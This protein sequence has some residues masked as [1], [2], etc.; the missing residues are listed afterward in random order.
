MIHCEACGKSFSEVFE[1]IP[2][3]HTWEEYR[4]AAAQ[5]NPFDFQAWKKSHAEWMQT[6]PYPQDP[7]TEVAWKHL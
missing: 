5:H 1:E 4:A 7:L 6:H 3:Y 2:H